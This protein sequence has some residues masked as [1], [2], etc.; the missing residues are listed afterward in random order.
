MSSAKYNPTTAYVDLRINPFLQ[1]L[2]NQCKPRDL[3]GDILIP[4]F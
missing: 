2:K 4:Q 1:S 3:V